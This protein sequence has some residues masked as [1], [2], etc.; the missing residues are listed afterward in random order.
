MILPHT[1]VRTTDQKNIGSQS[2]TIFDMDILELIIKY[3]VIRTN[4]YTPTFPKKASELRSDNNNGLLVSKSV[5]F[6]TVRTPCT[7]EWCI[8]I[9]NIAIILNNSKLVWRCLLLLNDLILQIKHS[10]RNGFFL[11]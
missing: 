5:V 2:F 9:I 10:I 4:R 1:K 6:E 11:P 7:K 8:T 3:P